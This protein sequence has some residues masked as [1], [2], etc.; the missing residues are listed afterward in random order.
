M[1][2]KCVYAIFS[3]VNPEQVLRLVSALRNLSPKA[4]IVVHHDPAHIGP[5]PA[6]VLRAGGTLVPNPIRGEWGDWSIVLQHL[7]VMR[8]CVSNLEFDWFIT[9]TGQSYPIRRLEELEKFLASSQ[10][11]AYL[12]NFD[13][14]DPA[15]WPDG[16]AAKRYHYRY[17]KLPKFRYWHR[18]PTIVRNGVP[19]AIRAFNRVQTLLKVFLYPRSL[20]TRLGILYPRRPFDAA[21]LKLGGGNLNANYRRTAVVKILEYVDSHPAYVAYFS[22]TALPDEAFFATILRNSPSLHIEN[23]SL[24]YI[25]WPDLHS[26]SGGVMGL[27]HLPE[28]EASS[29]YF[30]L[31]FDQ[32]VCP[33]LLDYIDHKLSLPTA[34]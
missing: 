7:Y 16:E 12:T 15:V 29:A 21:G 8:W 18:L 19:P 5:D 27:S 17:F 4:H 10:A 3:H 26:A 28:L 33:K 13:A 6:E 11:E 14:Y 2:I 31:K 22:R 1:T 23:D 25:Y 32:N 9:L 30:A 24:R 20:P 34:I